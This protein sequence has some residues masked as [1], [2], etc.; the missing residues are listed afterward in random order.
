MD[1]KKM[2][3]K[4][5]ERNKKELENLPKIKE[6]ETEVKDLKSKREYYI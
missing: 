4:E 6:I 1:S 5:E 3:S 2:S